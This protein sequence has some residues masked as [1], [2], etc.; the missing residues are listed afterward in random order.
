MS[1]LREEM[2][3]EMGETDSQGRTMQD[4]LDVICDLESE[5]MEADD[6]E[7]R[8]FQKGVEK[9]A[10]HIKENKARIVKTAARNYMVDRLEEEILALLPASEEVKK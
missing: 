1:R 9:A 5:I 8:G 6:A 4:L 3:W 2:K 7:A 10:L